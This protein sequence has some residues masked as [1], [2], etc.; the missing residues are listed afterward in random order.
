[1]LQQVWQKLNAN[2]RLVAIGA[3]VILVSWVVGLTGYGVGNSAIALLGSLAALAI[4]YLKYAPNQN[5]TWPAPVPLLLLGISVI[6]GI[7]EL[8]VLLSLLSFFGALGGYLGFAAG[9]LIGAI[10]TIVGA[11]IMLW[12]S[13]KEYTATKTTA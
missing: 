5:I 9:Y 4:L 7:I 2:E 8:T 11:A 1:M 13:Y 10:G 3:I 12:G 6:V